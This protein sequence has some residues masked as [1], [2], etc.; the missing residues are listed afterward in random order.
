MEVS[1]SALIS[2]L[3]GQAVIIIVP[4]V[5]SATNG[6]RKAEGSEQWGRSVSFCVAVTKCQYTDLRTLTEWL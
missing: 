4:C 3:V 1:A 5:L 6:M 2:W